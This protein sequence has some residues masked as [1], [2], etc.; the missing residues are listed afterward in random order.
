MTGFN[1]GGQ[2]FVPG[3]PVDGVTLDLFYNSTA[4]TGVTTVLRAI[5]AAGTACTM[6]IKPESTGLTLTFI[7][8]PDTVPVTATPAGSLD[9]GSVHFSQMGSVAGSW[10]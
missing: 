5:K 7:C 9:M 1:E 6:T 3:L 8:F 2:N 10:A 4:T